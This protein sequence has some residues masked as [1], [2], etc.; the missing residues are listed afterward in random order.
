MSR[1]K[2][3]YRSWGIPCTGKRVYA[4]R[5]RLEWLGKIEEAGVRRRAEFTYTR[6]LVSFRIDWRRRREAMKTAG[7][8]DQNRWATMRNVTTEYGNITKPDVAS[9]TAVFK[10]GGL[11]CRLRAPPI[12]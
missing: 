10:S 1:L 2:T 5:H 3:T 8:E 6:L 9:W 12:T 4:P 7:N 11:T